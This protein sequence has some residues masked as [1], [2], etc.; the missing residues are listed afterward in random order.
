M[1][2]FPIPV[3]LGDMMRDIAGGVAEAARILPEQSR[4]EV[5]AV[6]VKRATVR[7]DFEMTG[8]ARRRDGTVGIG[9]RTF[10]IT[11]ARRVESA[12]STAR[13]S[14]QITLEI[15]AVADAGSRSDA[16]APPPDEPGR[17]RDPKTVMAVVNAIRAEVV[18]RRDDGGLNTRTAA[19]HLARLDEAAEAV[20]RGDV[21]AAL[22][23]IKPIAEALGLA[24]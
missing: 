24:V 18:R 17:L 8:S 14:G 1:A 10:A 9:A 2:K 16:P 4:S 22:A 20:V 3:G 11:A 21:E 6:A 5:G 19:I 12:E 23:I 7:V 13:N 15:V